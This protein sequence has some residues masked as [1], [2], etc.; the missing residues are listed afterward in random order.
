VDDAHVRATDILKAQED[1]LHTLAQ[2]LLEYETLSGD[3]IK[4]VVETGKIDRP[5]APVGT[6]CLPPSAAPA[7]RARA[8]G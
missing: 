2:A 8:A 1:K 6:R 7:C 4:Q 3:E 5:D